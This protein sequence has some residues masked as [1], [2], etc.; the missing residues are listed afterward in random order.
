MQIADR[1]ALEYLTDVHLEV[2][3][4]R[5]HRFGLVPSQLVLQST[6]PRSVLVALLDIH[7]QLGTC[8]LITLGASGLHNWTLTV[9]AAAAVV[10]ACGVTFSG[11][12]AAL[13]YDL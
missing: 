8:K 9:V 11:G 12:Y 10:L 2:L 4:H 13:R 6:N 7:L 1:Q 5:L 3:P